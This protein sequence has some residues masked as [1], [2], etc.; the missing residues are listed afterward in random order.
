MLIR[1]IKLLLQY[2][3]RP[4]KQEMFAGKEVFKQ[5]VYFAQ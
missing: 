3:M 4:G 5:E 2:R 1:M